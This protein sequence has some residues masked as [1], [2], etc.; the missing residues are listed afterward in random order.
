MS[1]YKEIQALLKTLDKKSQ[2]YLDNYLKGAPEWV[3]DSFCI[4]NYPSDYT[5]IKQGSTIEVISILIKGVVKGT[6]YPVFG[7]IYD[8]MWFDSVKAF[9]ALE[10]FTKK[11]QFY[12]T[13]V[14]ASPC[15]MLLLPI[16]I[17]QKWMQMDQNAMYID[18][19]STTN[20]LIYEVHRERVYI[21]MQGIE[22]LTYFLILYYKQFAQDGT[23]VI[24]LTR[25]QIS[26]CTGL[27]I[28]TINRG[29]TSLIEKNYLQKTGNALVIE[30][31][32]YHHLKEMLIDIL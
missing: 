30:K 24:P 21:F 22:R 10:Y 8:F 31:E 17:Y 28:R 19:S 12:A 27:S 23:C 3:Y 13:L 4:A 14:T 9:G 7:V 32:Q 11:N 1:K 16:S 25:Q 15:T 2:D 6:D 18:A 26:D 29:I 20:Q 5:F